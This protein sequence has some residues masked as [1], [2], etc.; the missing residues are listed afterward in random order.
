MDKN[1]FDLIV[2]KE[3]VKRFKPDLEGLRKILSHYSNIDI[4]Y[5]GNVGKIN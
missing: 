2:S 1:F 3:P 4:L 5:I